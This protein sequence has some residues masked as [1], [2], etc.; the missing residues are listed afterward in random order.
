[1]RLRIALACLLAAMP[2][3]ATPAMAFDYEGYDPT[4][5]VRAGTLGIGPEVSVRIPGSPFGVRADVNYF[6]F[7]LD[8]VS[9]SHYSATAGGT[10]YEGTLRYGGTLRLLSGGIAGDYYPFKGLGL[11][12]SAGLDISGNGIDARASGP[13]GSYGGTTGASAALGTASARARLT[14]DAV[15][16]LLSVGWSAHVSRRVVLSAEIG[17]LLEGSPKVSVDTSEDLDAVPGLRASVRQ[18]ASRVQR[19]VDVPVLPVVMVGIGYE[20]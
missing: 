19:D 7:S 14:T 20:F 3:L 2:S 1:M 9:S 18:T 4:A 16:P 17:A 12:L 13:I 11:R 8:D 10:S 15:A 5:S 6:D